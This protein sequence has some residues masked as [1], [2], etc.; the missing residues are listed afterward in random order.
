[1]REFAASGAKRRLPLP[2]PIVFPHGALLYGS[3]V[4]LCIIGAAAVLLWRR[5]THAV[6]LAAVA[7]AGLGA[8]PLTLSRADET[9]ITAIALLI[10]GVLPLA[11]AEIATHLRPTSAS[12]RLLR[13]ATALSVVWGVAALV[14]VGLLADTASLVRGSVYHGAVV[15]S[16][17]RTF[18]LAG[19]KDAAQAQQVL[20]AVDRVAR[21]GQSIFVGPTNLRRAEYGPTYMYYLLPQLRP[22]SY[23]TVINPGVVN[24]PNSTLAH[25]LLRADWL[26]LVSKWDK[27][28][29]PYAGPLGPAAPNKV[30]R[31]N[32]CL[33]LRS[34][35][36][37]LYESRRLAPRFGDCAEPAVLL[38]D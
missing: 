2:S 3:A 16:E 6:A 20:S 9:H 30:V 17:G 8:V 24:A 28:R 21:R 22:A 25:D 38:G 14:G 37:R 35:A 34:G 18:I 7:A 31:T 23:Y 29:E 4:A 5:S 1:M 13:S 32:F 15:R 11:A 10:Y 33:R 26:I 36:Y 27:I 19:K 12:S